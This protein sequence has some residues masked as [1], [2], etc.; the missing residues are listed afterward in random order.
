MKYCA[1]VYVIPERRGISETLIPD[2]LDFLVSSSKIYKPPRLQSPCSFFS[3]S[4]CCA[5]AG[6]RSKGIGDD[7]DGRVVGEC[8]LN[9]FSICGCK[10][11][12]FR[13]LVRDGSVQVV[14]PDKY[15]Y[16]TVSSNNGSP[17]SRLH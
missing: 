6:F 17:D 15:H 13:F 3:S 16:S 10:I 11:C 2:G 9:C 12:R 14:R 7:A 4:I 1:V 5:R 8:L